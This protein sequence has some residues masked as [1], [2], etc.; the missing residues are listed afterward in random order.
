[1]ANII[2]GDAVAVLKAM[3]RG[4]ID[5]VYLDPPFGTQVDWVGKAGR[6]S[7]RF[8]WDDA[9]CSLWAAMAVKHPAFASVLEACPIEPRDRAYLV[10]MVLLFDELRGVLHPAGSLWLHC[11]DTMGAYLRL[12]LDAVFGADNAIGGLIWKRTNSH[13]HRTKGF[14]RIHDSIFVYGRSRVSR[15]RL[16]RTKH[17]FID[18][19]PCSEGVRVTGYSEIQL[20]TTSRERVGY[21]TQKPVGLLEEIV[22]AG[23]LPGGVVLDPTCGSG[24]TLV[25]AQRLGRQGIGIDQSEDACRVA[26]Q[27]LANLQV[28]A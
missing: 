12:A 9:S 8:V 11:D 7:D 26:R 25:A 6:F 23:S 18:G 10:R 21:P 19:D 2:R 15:W 4:S 14:G 28:A 22:A 13:N 16:W 17:R 1:M 27:R 3:P 20:N 24:T 5:Q